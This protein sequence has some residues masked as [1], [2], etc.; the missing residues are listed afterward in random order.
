[1]EESHSAFESYFGKGSAEI[2]ENRHGLIAASDAALAQDMNDRRSVT[3]LLFLY[4]SVAVAWS[5]NKMVELALST[6][7]AE[8]RAM[9]TCTKKTLHLR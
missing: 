4:N 8:A 6:N 5:C 3:S 7:S 1:M 9:F 2:K